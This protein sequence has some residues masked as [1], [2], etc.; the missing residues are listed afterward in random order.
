MLDHVLAYLRNY[1]EIGYIC[2]TF[3]IK[4]GT[5]S[6][7]EVSDGQY[8]RIVGSVF[9]DGVHQN[10]AGNLTDEAFTGVVWPLAVPK[11]V[12]D[13][14]TEI[15]AWQEKNGTAASGLYQS[16]S[17]GGYSYSMKSGGGSSDVY[18]WQNAFASRLNRWRKI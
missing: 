1:F 8:F 2:G 13:I 17:F 7:P 14:V 6:L 10:P 5:L 11:A 16:E 3:E 18:S 9:N 12:I 4:D 15:E